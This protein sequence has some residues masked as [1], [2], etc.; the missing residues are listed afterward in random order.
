VGDGEDIQV[1]FR[2]YDGSLHWHLSMRRLGADRHGVWLGHPAGGVMR[3]GDGPPIP[4]RHAHVGLIP[5]AGWTAWFNSAP[6]AIEIYCDVT[7]VPVWPTDRE[8]TMVDLD[9]DVCRLR[10]DGSVQL[11]DEDEFAAH[12]IRYGYPHDVV[13]AASRTAVRLRAALGDGTEPFAAAY[14]SWL[15]LVQ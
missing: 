12:Q 5:P 9:L 1:V 8:V 2:K 11:L 13:D 15:A 3:K 7:T 10:A 6:E 4:I 14:R